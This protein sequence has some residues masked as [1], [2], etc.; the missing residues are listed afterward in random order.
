MQDN[1]D[2]YITNEFTNQ[3][4]VKMQALLDQQLPVEPK[5]SDWK[6]YVLL[7]LCTLFMLSSISLAYLYKTNPL[8][9]EVIV[10]K[11]IY[12]Q[13]EQSILESQTSEKAGLE[14]SSISPQNIKSTL[15]STI[16]S[17]IDYTAHT[18]TY[19]L[20]TSLFPTQGMEASLTSDLG[21]DAELGQPELDPVAPIETNIP[22]LYLGEIEMDWYP[23]QPQEKQRRQRRQN[24]IK[25]EVGW[26]ISLTSDMQFSG[27]GLTSG[28]SFSL[29]DRL[30]INTGLGIN[31]FDGERWLLGGPSDREP[32]N[33]SEAYYQGLRNFKQ[34]Y[35]PLSLDYNITKAFVLNSGLNVRYT[36]SEEI[37]SKLPPLG[38][39]NRSRRSSNEVSIFNSTNLGF[40]AGVKYRFNPHWSILLDSEWGMTNLFNRTQYGSTTPL[41]YELNVINLKTNYTF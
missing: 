26:L 10:E 9:K 6:L 32:S 4:W 38:E 12:Q 2:D 39:P 11:I 19:Q 20:A 16:Q 30:A 21:V 7:G 29:T 17:A 13:Q 35:V 14:T 23:E 15:K 1:T 40:S 41:H 5:K 25:F 24:S 8:I 18:N 31:T 34:L 22:A 3:S 37:D 33:L 28:V 27:L 36:Y